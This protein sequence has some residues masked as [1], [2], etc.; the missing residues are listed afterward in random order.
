MLLVL[1]PFVISQSTLGAH[2][3]ICVLGK[4]RPS[5]Y[6]NRRFM[7][8]VHSKL[9]ICDD[10]VAIV[11][12]ANINMRSLAG[13]RD[14]EIGALLF[15]PNHDVVG[16][17]SE[18]FMPR[19]HVHGFRM[20]LFAEH[21]KVVYPAE[22]DLLRDPSTLE[23]SRLIQKRA[24]VLLTS[25]KLHHDCVALVDM[26][27]GQVISNKCSQT[28]PITRAECCRITG[29]SSSIQVLTRTPLAT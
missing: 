14:T 23:C 19:G 6:R 9:M 2:V 8:Y 7:V 22:E 29:M 3:C 25:S 17:G 10:A 26:I 28:L 5:A 24:K 18:V 12:S 16:S 13:T 21:L 15:Q 27:C 20:S 1:A 11:G 4:P